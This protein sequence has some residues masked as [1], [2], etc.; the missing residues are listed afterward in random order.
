[1]F[2]PDF[3]LPPKPLGPLSHPGQA[4]VSGTATLI[5]NLSVNAIPIISYAQEK[6]SVAVCNFRFYAVRLSVTECVS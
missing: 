3:Q 6:L 1:V 4:P 5:E 2:T